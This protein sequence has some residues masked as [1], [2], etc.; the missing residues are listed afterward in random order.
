MFSTFT[1]Y[2]F[3]NEAKSYCNLVLYILFQCLLEKGYEGI[4]WRTAEKKFLE[5]VPQIMNSYHS[6]L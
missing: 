1:V 2:R 3:P 4:S 5:A 6:L